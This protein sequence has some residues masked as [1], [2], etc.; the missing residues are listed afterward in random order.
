MEPRIQE[1]AQTGNVELLQEAIKSDSLTL[2]R[3]GISTATGDTP[4][5]IACLAG[6]L[7]FVIELL[8]HGHGKEFVYQLNPDGLSPLHI[9]AATGHVDI[10]K[11]LLKVDCGLCLMRGRGKRIPLHCAAVKGRVD[12]VREL[13]LASAESIEFTTSRGETALHLAVKNNQLQVLSVMVEQAE[14]FDVINWKDE[15]GDT[16]L[17]LAAAKKQHEVVDLLVRGSSSRGIEVNSMNGMGNTP[18]DMLHTGPSESGDIAIHNILAKAGGLR[19][20]EEIQRQRTDNDILSASPAV[21]VDLKGSSYLSQF[22][23]NPGRDNPDK[24]RNILLLIATLI[25]TSTFQAGLTP[26]KIRKNRRDEASDVGIRKLIV[27]EGFLEYALIV[28][29]I[30]NT[31]ALMS[32]LY[33]INILIKGFPLQREVRVCMVA[34]GTSYFVSMLIHLP[35]TSFYILFLVAL[36]LPLPILASVKVYRSVF[37]AREEVTRAEQMNQV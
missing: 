27:F 26:P 6:N 10:V 2:K 25:T 33:I 3:A 32:C 22:K 1:A 8:K 15:H 16:V 34:L 37:C 17:H 5:H 7:Q 4:L 18:L 19:A 36:T 23:F 29:L 12:V 11:E 35:E 13:L 30:F 31:L 9:A 21:D 20:T 28:F 24:V 14:K